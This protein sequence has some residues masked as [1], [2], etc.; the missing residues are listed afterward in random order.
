MSNKRKNAPAVDMSW[1]KE[2]TTLAKKAK[3]KK[4]NKDLNKAYSYP[5]ELIR[6]VTEIRWDP[7]L[8]KIDKVRSKSK[9]AMDILEVDKKTLKKRKGARPVQVRIGT[10]PTQL[11]ETTNLKGRTL[12]CE[13]YSVTKLNGE[14]QLFLWHIEDLEKREEAKRERDEQIREEARR[15]GLQRLRDHRE[16]CQQKKV[17]KVPIS[18]AKLERKR[19]RKSSNQ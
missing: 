12:Y 6:D 4:G 3:T 19:K 17:Q 15:L 13:S 14:Y 1:M 18:K 7:F 2:L 10:Q 11:I 5:E 16:L 9:K 8:F